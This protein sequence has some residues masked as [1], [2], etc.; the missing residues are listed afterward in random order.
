MGLYLSLFMSVSTFLRPP[1][2]PRRLRSF[3]CESL[4]NLAP[5]SGEELV[6]Q[7]Y[8]RF[9]GLGSFDSLGPEQ[10][11]SA[12]SAASAASKPRCDGVC[13]GLAGVDAVRSNL[14]PTTFG[15]MVEY[16]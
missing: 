13:F 9:R 12:V 14:P 4:S 16:S 6:A 1:L 11:D 3:I 15:A 2:P 7:R 5:L 10:R 8:E